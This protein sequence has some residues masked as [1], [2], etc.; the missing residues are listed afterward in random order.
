MKILSLIILGIASFSSSAFAE[1]ITPL[2]QWPILEKELLEVI[3]TGA[4]CGSASIESG[5][6]RLDKQENPT[7]TEAALS[8]MCRGQPVSD[9]ASFGDRPE[10][11][12]SR[13]KVADA[14]EA[15]FSTDLFA[16]NQ[17]ALKT[18]RDI[19]KVLHDRDQ[20]LRF[21]NPPTNAQN[22]DIAYNSKWVAICANARFSYSVARDLLKRTD[23]A[24]LAADEE[25]ANYVWLLV[26]HS[27]FVP[28]YQLEMSKY[29]G[30]VEKRQMKVHSA[31]LYDRAMVGLHKKQKFGTQLQCKD[32]VRGPFPIED[33]EGLD[34]RRT[35]LGLL[36]MEQH[37][38][39]FPRPCPQ[40]E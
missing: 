14:L 21:F 4:A 27:D 28:H 18:E 35:E 22:K 33:I 20:A 12:Q 36:P 5:F 16:F 19:F 37:L 8:G 7:Q 29:F 31:Y 25:L 17:E 6:C 11:W 3:R 34:A 38:A 10:D 9:L 40:P 26:Q 13:R 15:L 1:K 30:S 39:N 24:T 32:G 23:P 2:E